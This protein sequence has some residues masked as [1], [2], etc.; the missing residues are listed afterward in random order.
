[1]KKLILVLTILLQSVTGFCQVT[2]PNT[3]SAADKIYGLSKFWQEV[4]YNFI[5]LDKVDK[6]CGKMPTKS[7]S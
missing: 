3:L 7:T 1:M 6:K 2:I 5:Y 4:N